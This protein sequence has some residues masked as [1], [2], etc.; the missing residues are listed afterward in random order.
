MNAMGILFGHGARLG[1]EDY[2]W[3]DAE[4]TQLATNLEMVQ[5]GTALAATFNKRV[6]TSREVRVALG[7]LGR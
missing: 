6:A 1:L 4:R 3:L 2:L 5:R 7:L